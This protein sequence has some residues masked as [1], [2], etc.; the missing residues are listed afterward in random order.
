M[1]NL[2][3]AICSKIDGLNNRFDKLMSLPDKIRE[4]SKK[5]NFP[6]TLD[7]DLY[8]YDELIAMV[9]THYRNVEDQSTN[10]SD[11]NRLD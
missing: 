7:I 6:E 3:I 8:K 11:G 1:A 5:D 10:T 4:I 9:K 2:T